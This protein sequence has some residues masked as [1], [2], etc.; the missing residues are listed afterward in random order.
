MAIFELA[1]NLRRF[2]W[3]VLEM[4]YEE[5]VKWQIYFERRP[6][7][8]RDD[9][10]CSK[11]LKAQGVKEKPE[12]LFPTLAAVY[13]SSKPAVGNHNHLNFKKS[14]FFQHISKAVNGEKLDLS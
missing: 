5:F 2:V 3:E 11:L 10:R 13:N 1:Y 7:D 12:N 8:W 14:A 9:D 6:V 4:P